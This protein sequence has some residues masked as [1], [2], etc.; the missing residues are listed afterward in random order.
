MNF[1]KT[2]H[3]FVAAYKGPKAI[4]KRRDDS[5]ENHRISPL[6]LACLGGP[7]RLDTR[8]SGAVLQG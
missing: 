3:L 1:C 7:V 5:H 2:S 4:V 6:N 8:T